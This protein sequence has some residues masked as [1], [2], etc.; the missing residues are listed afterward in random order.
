MSPRGKGIW[1][2]FSTTDK[3]GG[4][5]WG[6]VDVQL[7]NL[8]SISTPLDGRM[9][10]WQVLQTQPGGLWQDLGDETIISDA[11]ISGLWEDAL[12][13]TLILEGRSKNLWTEIDD[14]TITPPSDDSLQLWHEVGE[15]TIVLTKSEQNIWEKA[16]GR[17][18][19]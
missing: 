3:S 10:I 12:D 16:S 18:D 6:E 15:E 1:G 9:S 8:A 19:F 4:G 11:S 13:E 7:K 2:R 5:V 17:V 14:R